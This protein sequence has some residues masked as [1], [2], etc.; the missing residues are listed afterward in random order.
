[1]SLAF[2]HTHPH[3]LGWKSYRLLRK[4]AMEQELS[5]SG[6]V[7][8]L[9]IAF[10]IVAGC[11]TVLH[12]IEQSLNASNAPRYNQEHYLQAGALARSVFG[13]HAVA[14]ATAEYKAAPVKETEYVTI[15]TGKEITKE[16]TF[17]NTGSLSW[18]PGVVTFET[19]PFLKTVSQVKTAAWKKVYEP[20]ALPK[21]IKPGQSVTLSFKMKAPPLEGTIQENF[22]LVANA[23]PLTGS[24]VRVFV[25]IEKANAVSAPVPSTPVSPT[26]AAAPAATGAT[27]VP[28]PKLCI[29]TVDATNVSNCN[30]NPNENN[31]GNGISS[32]MLLSGQP[33]IRVGLFSTL[34]AQRITAN[35]IFSVYGGNQLLA[36]SLPAGT[37]V[38]LGYNQ[39]NGQYSVS[40]PLVTQQTASPLRVVPAFGGIVTLLDYRNGQSPQDNRFRNI[41]EYRYTVPAKTVWLI[42]E[43]PLDDYIKGLAETTNASPVEFQKVMATIARTYALYHY[44]RGVQFGLVDASTKHSADHFHI[45]SVYDQVYRGYN[46]E[47]RLTGLTQAV[48]ATRGVAVTY[49][50]QIVITPYFS[51][52]DGRTRDWTEVWGGAAMAWLKSVLVPE[53][54]GKTL[55]GHGVGLSARGA[56]LMVNNG[57]GWQE[58]LKYF[59]TGTQVQKVY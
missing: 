2:S 22:Q 26:P 31:A 13:V 46:S 38:T 42:N 51:N 15:N 59:Y 58:V 47:L 32:N 48:E 37:V 19:G 18:K 27:V 20:A 40:L 44:L 8:S 6:L 7:I 4:K 25:T 23:H 21:E 57:K 16:I 36:S 34:A 17:K 5:W 14:A 24:L 9:S 45:D 35:T 50:N 28:Q 56:L 29:A 1:M 12:T 30:T 49:N 53:D 33:T 11:A 39:S 41:V 54:N 52:S 3:V 55:F 43:L 10:F